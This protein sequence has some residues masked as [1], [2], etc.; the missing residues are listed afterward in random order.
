MRRIRIRFRP[1]GPFGWAG[2]GYFAGLIV[3][4]VLAQVVTSFG[5]D[6]LNI[7]L[8]FL[9]AAN[10]FGAAYSV[11]AVGKARALVNVLMREHAHHVI[12]IYRA[13]D[14]G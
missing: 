4:G 2:V 11:Y 3:T 9:C 13:S 12:R 7:V 1:L 6:W 10:L 8:I 14:D 5:V